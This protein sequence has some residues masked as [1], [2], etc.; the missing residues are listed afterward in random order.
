MRHWSRK[1]TVV[2]A[3]MAALAAVTGSVTPSQAAAAFPL[4][5]IGVVRLHMVNNDQYVRFD[6]SN[7]SGGYT[8]G[9]PNPIVVSSCLATV[10]GPLSVTS[11]PA[12]PTGKL[13]FVDHEF[14]V[15]V[16]GEGNGTPCGRVDGLNQA[17]TLQLA[18]AL[19]TDE[20]DY[21][22]LDVEV[23]FGGTVRAELYFGSQLMRVEL[24]PTGGA[25]DSG[26]DSADGDNYRFRL[27]AVGTTSVFNKI[28]LKLDPSTP[29]GAF[30]LAGGED[31]TAPQPGGLGT[32][33]ATSDSLFHITDV[34]G[35]LNCG[36][37]VTR[38]TTGVPISSL[39]RQP[40]GLGGCVAIPYILRTANNGTNQTVQLQKDLGS[41][42]DL[43]PAF[44]MSTTWAPELATYPVVRTTQIDYGGGPQ[45]MQWCNGTS[46]MPMTP[47]G[48][49][50]CITGQSV[51]V[52]GTG[53]IQVTESYFGAGDPKYIR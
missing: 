43:Q 9:T 21:A 52:V 13:G 38:G 8:T 49:A 47:T 19:A 22:E 51:A 32:T 41:Q 25:S 3:A 12:A 44:T 48:Q 33:L 18:G 20:F 45:P 17:L 14:G 4:P 16:K 46:S 30:S 53:L 39:T 10:S 42:A 11:T 29:G 27:P 36:D 7:G 26:P 6:P 1:L 37:T 5:D 23:K 34:D 50:W 28:V 2:L 35:I 24:L 40:N 15:Q 31:G